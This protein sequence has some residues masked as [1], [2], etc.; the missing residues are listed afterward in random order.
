V[1][2]GAEQV[3][4]RWNVLI[5]LFVV[6]LSM[7]FQFQSVASMSPALMQQ[8]GVGLGDIG[9]LISLYLA[10]GL[11]FALPGGEIGRRFGDKRV[12]LFGLVLVIAGGLAMAFAPSWGWQIAGRIVA[13]IGG[14]L[15]N[16]LMSKMVTDWFAGKEIATAMAIFVN[17][18]PAGIALCLFVLPALA[19]AEGITSALLLTTAFCAI[20]LVLLATLYR[21]P[22]QMAAAAT[23]APAAS[24][25]WP[26]PPVTRAVV[27]AGFI[28]GLFNAAIGMV[29]GFGI[30]MLVERGWS[31]AAAGSAT[32]LV[33]WLVSASVPIGGFL[34]DRTG[35]PI[36]IMLAGFALFAIALLTAAR[37][38]A[39][40]PAFVAL[41]LVGGLSAGPIMSLPARILT[42]QWRAVGMGIYFTLFYLFVVSAPVVAGILSSR[43]G[44]A[45]VAFDFGAFMLAMC[46]PAYWAFNRLAARVTSAA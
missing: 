1:G 40:I 43:A 7:A 36:A 45:A 3:T 42:P 20:G 46:F 37:T 33:L 6:R 11:A 41:G 19:A 27:S 23:A 31:L 4:R 30:T 28:W 8:Y 16:V 12:V 10:P 9:F 2:W 14:V 39:V 34:A 25:S 35:K 38:D 15:L 13:G 32:S 5:L 44:T 26:S 24:I 22:A 29:F 21:P 17:S 18:W